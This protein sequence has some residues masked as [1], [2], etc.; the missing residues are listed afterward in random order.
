MELHPQQ[1]AMLDHYIQLARTNVAWDTYAREQVRM[2]ANKEPKRWGFL[3]AAL[4]LA[5][6]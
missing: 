6:S 2:M 3:P 5:L 1:Q 4:S